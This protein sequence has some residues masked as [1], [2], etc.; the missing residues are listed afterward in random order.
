MPGGGRELQSGFTAISQTVSVWV[1]LVV[2]WRKEGRS[3][4]VDGV[5]ENRR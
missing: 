4:E 2:G 5:G 3:R 1:G